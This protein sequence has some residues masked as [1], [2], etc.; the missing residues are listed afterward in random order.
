MSE[1]YTEEWVASLLDVDKRFGDAGPGELLAG[2]A[3]GDT[4]VDYGC[5][6]GYFTLAAARLVGPEGR[7]YAVDLE[8]RMVELVRRR[9]AEADLP[10]VV[11]VASDGTRADLADGIAD[12]V[13][14][15][16][17]MHYANGRD[18][19]AAVA[20]DLR[21]LLKSDGRVLVAQ[22]KPKRR[23]SGLSY[24]DLADIM[25]DAGLAAS[26]AHSITDELYYTVARRQPS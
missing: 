15:V 24:A 11:A 20:R 19:Q 25:G 8:P 22:W 5:G 1:R 18:G 14:C 17:I 13:I 23:A 2:V 12:Y 7:V 3:P 26:G 10:N 6:P 9:A 21:R 4:V 16:Q